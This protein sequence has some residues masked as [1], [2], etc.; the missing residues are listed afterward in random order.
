MTMKS[1]TTNDTVRSSLHRPRVSFNVEVNTQGDDMGSVKDADPLPIV[2]LKPFVQKV[3]RREKS[4][5]STWERS[6]SV[7]TIKSEKSE[8]NVSK[9]RD[10]ETM[11]TITL[12]T[13]VDDVSSSPPPKTSHSLPSRLT[14]RFLTVYVNAFEDFD[15][16]KE[17]F[18]KIVAESGFKGRTRLHPVVDSK[19]KKQPEHT[20]NII[21]GFIT[22]DDR[23]K[24]TLCEI[25]DG[26]C[27][28]RFYSF[29][30]K[31]IGPDEIRKQQLLRV[32]GETIDHNKRSTPQN[33]SPT[34]S[35]II[36]GSWHGSNVRHGSPASMLYHNKRGHRSKR[37]KT[38][39]YDHLDRTGTLP[40]L[41]INST[42]LKRRSPKK[43]YDN[44]SEDYVDY[45]DA[46]EPEMK[47]NVGGIENSLVV[48]SKHGS[49][50]KVERQ[51]SFELE[52][53][54]S[55]FRKLK[56]YSPFE[57]NPSELAKYYPPPTFNM[58]QG[59]ARIRQA[60]Q[61][62]A[63]KI[64]QRKLRGGRNGYGS[65]F[66]TSFSEM[67]NDQYTHGILK[68]SFNRID[69]IDSFDNM[70]NPY[71]RASV[72]E[73]TPNEEP[74]VPY[75][76][77]RSRLDSRHSS[78]VLNANVQEKKEQ[79]A[80]KEVIQKETKLA[81]ESE[82]RSSA[83]QAPP[84][85]V[86]HNV[87]EGNDVVIKEDVDTKTVESVIKD[88]NKITKETAEIKSVKMKTAQPS[89]KQIDASGRTFITS[90]SIPQMGMVTS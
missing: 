71:N 72:Q 40:S 27:T 90:D 64:K 79:V 61:S 44:N 9:T 53:N 86:E 80:V 47:H 6:P 54:L 1:L 77:P 29:N 49:P 22:R 70:Y 2:E 37:T 14:E 8:S 4:F 33:S 84:P 55:R 36:N 23:T 26:D 69:H 74:S 20:I 82:I 12:D 11:S 60:M 76:T 67:H 45:S 57:I 58:T 13:G 88:E 41:S 52:S 62:N 21:P 56:D 63:S 16:Q 83:T 46:Y 75:D 7:A 34:P 50:T 42:S 48:L 38:P 51:I 73:F 35:K 5:A 81:S 59:E 18:H 19:M 30:P 25:S 85:E 39:L 24:T 28:N 68:N 87:K 10:S 3:W 17:H 15:T 89:V 65:S 31:A 78:K 66:S 32:S 43:V